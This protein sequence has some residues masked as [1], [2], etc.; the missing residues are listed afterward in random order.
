MYVGVCFCCTSVF[1]LFLCFPL[2]V[3]VYSSAL[4]WSPDLSF[5]NT[6][7]LLLPLFEI[8]YSEIIKR[9]YPC[10]KSDLVRIAIIKNRILTTDAYNLF[11]GLPEK[12]VP[13]TKIAIINASNNIWTYSMFEHKRIVHK[14]CTFTFSVFL[15]RTHPD[16]VSPA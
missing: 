12:K 4:V 8:E 2:K 14:P 3:N 6:Y 16:N 5:L 13:S 15:T 9:F 11:V 10:E 7:I 1:L